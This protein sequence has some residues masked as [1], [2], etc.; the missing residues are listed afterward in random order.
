MSVF[1][2]CFSSRPGFLASSFAENVIDELVI[3]R[4]FCLN[5]RRVIHYGLKL[6]VLL[7][8]FDVLRVA[9]FD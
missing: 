9:V 1:S 8:F 7:C 6:L 2:K 3:F 4:R 5:E